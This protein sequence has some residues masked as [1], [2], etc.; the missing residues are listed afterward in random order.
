MPTLRYRVEIDPGEVQGQIASIAQAVSGGLQQTLQL[1][2]QGVGLVGQATNTVMRDLGTLWAG[3]GSQGVAGPQLAPPI[4]SAATDI[5]A[6]SSFGLAMAAGGFSTAPTNMFQGQFQELAQ[7]EMGMRQGMAGRAA[8]KGAVDVA[9]AAAWFLPGPAG[10]L[11]GGAME[12]A[13]LIAGAGIEG[14]IARNRLTASM[15]NMGMRAGAGTVGDIAT[16]F[17]ISRQGISVPEAVGLAQAG[18]ESGAINV[19]GDVSRLPAETRRFLDNVREMSRALRATNDE[20]VGVISELRG[21]GLTQNEIQQTGYAIAAAGGPGAGRRLLQRAGTGAQIARQMGVAPGIGAAIGANAGAMAAGVARNLDPGTLG[22]VGGTAAVADL[23]TQASMNFA[24]TGTGRR[25]LAGLM[26]PGGE[27]DPIAME[28]FRRGNISWQQIQA[29]AVQFEATAGGQ[30]VMSQMARDPGRFAPQAELLL[31]ATIRTLAPQIMDPLGNDP[32]AARVDWAMTQLGVNAAQARTIRGFAEGETARRRRMAR[33]RQEAALNQRTEE[34]LRANTLGARWNRFWATTE[35]RIGEQLAPVGMDLGAMAYAPGQFFRGIFRG[36]AELVVGGP[37]EAAEESVRA[38]YAAGNITRRQME[39]EIGRLTRDTAE[40]GLSAV[41]EKLVPREART[42]V[43]G[44]YRLGARR[45]GEA[46]MSQRSKESMMQ[47]AAANKSNQWVQSRTDL[48]SEDKSALM[49]LL[50][51]GDAPSDYKG[52]ITRLHRLASEALTVGA[53]WRESAARS[54]RELY[55]G[56]SAVRA[57]SDEERLNL[58]QRAQSI[59]MSSVSL[60]QGLTRMLGSSAQSAIIDSLERENLDEQAWLDAMEAVRLG[61]FGDLPEE[62]LPAVMRATRRAQQGGAAVGPVI[63]RIRAQ[64]SSGAL[65]ELPSGMLVQMANDDLAQRA[66]DQ[67]L[68]A[69]YGTNKGRGDK[70]GAAKKPKMD[71]PQED[72]TS[73]IAVAINNNSKVMSDLT[74][75]LKRLENSNALRNA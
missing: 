54:P 31:G 73:R 21:M 11:V 42:S 41:A 72:P 17:G 74:G 25:V 45:I 51:K 28:Q 35:E 65:A 66:I 39:R 2:Q 15:T 8:L 30:R 67:D 26:G 36:T 53:R 46:E 14:Q 70:E 38:E 1:G 19:Q 57:L 60:D 52:D 6:M 10:W 69:A 16:Q 22:A 23:W 27:V 55:Q 7:R 37:A 9:A 12:G 34:V 40:T 4:A 32:E 75:V 63:S 71:I 13:S 68:A 18:V 3:F 48:S 47:M 33:D 61:Q 44:L 20:A 62:L 56:M 59:G 50:S 49:H 64:V 24:A 5:Q 29:R 58:R 43:V